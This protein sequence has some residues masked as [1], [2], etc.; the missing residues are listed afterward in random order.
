MEYIRNSFK[1]QAICKT[2][3]GKHRFPHTIQIASI[4]RQWFPDI[5][6]AATRFTADS[7]IHSPK[8]DILNRV[9]AMRKSFKNYAM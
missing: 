4:Q 9:S 1:K 6:L 8:Q 7:Q 5:V 2:T 3:N